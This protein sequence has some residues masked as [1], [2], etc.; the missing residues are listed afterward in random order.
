M[1]MTIRPAGAGDREGWEKLYA[2]YAAFYGVA[3]SAEMRDRVWGWLGT[4]SS[5]LGALVAEDG[6]GRLVGLAHYR[7]FL[8]PLAAET[9]LYLDDLFVEPAARGQGVAA[10]L[11]EAVAAEGRA[12]GRGLLRWITAE[13]NARAR[14]LYDRVA[15]AT[16][17]VTYDMR[18]AA[19]APL[20][21]R[22]GGL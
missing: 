14:A 13:D 18:L 7:A 5:G 9:G 2:Q 11:I 8:R 6:A 22:D 12:R 3:Q 4:P 16:S 20:V 17:W 15:V 1:G 10:A 19:A 21:P